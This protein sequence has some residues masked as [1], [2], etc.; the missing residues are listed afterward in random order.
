MNGG[1]RSALFACIVLFAAPNYTCEAQ[2]ARDEFFLLP[3]Q[4]NIIDRR[5]AH[6]ITRHRTREKR[7]ALLSAI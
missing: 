1:F 6:G 5:G 3:G 7:S 2:A 4:D